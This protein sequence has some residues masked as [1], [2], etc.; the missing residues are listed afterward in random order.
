MKMDILKKAAALFLSGAMLTVST[1][2]PS[3]FM[4]SDAA[5]NK[6]RVSVH[7]PS[8]IKDGNTYSRTGHVFQMDMPE[9]IMWSS[10]ICRKI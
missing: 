9:R 2:I 3:H 7:D 5:A 8:I 6:A 1:H 10:V 4:A